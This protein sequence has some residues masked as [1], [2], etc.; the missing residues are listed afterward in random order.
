M[1]VASAKIGMF[2]RKEQSYA[3]DNIRYSAGAMATWISQF[4]HDGR[5]HS[6]PARDRGCRA[7]Y[8]VALRTPRIM[9]P[10]R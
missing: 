1:E 9:T 3:L 2:N 7:D 8:P 10:K 5:V 4:V 6:Y